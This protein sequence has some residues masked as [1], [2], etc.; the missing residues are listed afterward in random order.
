MRAS[1]AWSIPGR[2]CLACNGDLEQYCQFNATWTYN[3]KER[4]GEQ[5]T[6]GG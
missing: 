1:A 5:L 3:A 6:F 2:N 4:N